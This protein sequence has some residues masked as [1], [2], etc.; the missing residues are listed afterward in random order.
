LNQFSIKS[1]K[2][3]GF[4]G[5]QTVKHL[6]ETSCADVVDS[7]GVYMVLNTE[8]NGSFLEESIG[9][10]FKGRNPTVP[11]SE[12]RMNWVH[13]SEVVYIG[14]AGGFNSKAT[15]KKRLRQYMRFGQGAAV[16]HWGGRYIWQL[17]NS[18]NLTVCWKVLSSDE[19]RDIEAGLIQDFVRNYQCRPFAN[20]T[21]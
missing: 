3:S 11:V 5:F 4:E 15:L 13:E 10:H 12:L 21:G 1:L 16:G 18:M 20:L 8:P 9:G 2:D 17:Q 6:T 14:K 7:M 19:P